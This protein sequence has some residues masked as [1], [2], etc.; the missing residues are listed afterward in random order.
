MSVLIVDIRALRLVRAQARRRRGA[1]CT[2]CG[3][4]IT[5]PLATAL[6][7][8][9]GTAHLW[10]APSRAADVFTPPTEDDL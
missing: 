4:P 1:R 9:E 8:G 7:V 10:C 5:D 6:I 3:W 2:I